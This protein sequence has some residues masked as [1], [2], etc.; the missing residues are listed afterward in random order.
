[1]TPIKGRSIAKDFVNGEVRNIL[2]FTQ[3]NAARNGMRV[4]HSGLFRKITKMDPEFAN[5]NNGGINVYQ[6][7]C[8]MLCIVGNRAIYA[9][10]NSPYTVAGRLSP[11]GDEI[12]ARKAKSEKRNNDGRIQ[13]RDIQITKHHF[14][15]E[16]RIAC[17][18]VYGIAISVPSHLKSEREMIERLLALPG[19]EHAKLYI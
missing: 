17:G 8:E 9:V 12:K 10:S 6:S 14:E 3:Q 18:R 7:S 5:L 4:G 13:I 1:M 19:T 16:A 15:K 11:S 2:I